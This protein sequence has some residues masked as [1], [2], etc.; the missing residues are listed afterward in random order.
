MI[1]TVFAKEDNTIEVCGDMIRKYRHTSCYTVDIN[2][3]TN[4]DVVDDAEFK[5]IM[6]NIFR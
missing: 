1:D 4:P 3:E 5:P 6:A 2:P